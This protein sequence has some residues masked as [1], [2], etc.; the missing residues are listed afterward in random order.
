MEFYYGVDPAL[1][2]MELNQSE[3][4]KPFIEKVIAG[5]DMALE[6]E[7]P[8]LKMSE[9]LLTSQTGNRSIYEKKYFQRRRNCSSLMIA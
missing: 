6:A 4:A 3:V 2:R 5:A 9:F 7:E 8:A 1:K